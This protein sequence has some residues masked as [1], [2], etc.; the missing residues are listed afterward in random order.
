MCYYEIYNIIY[1]IGIKLINN[2]F[3]YITFTKY[4]FL[5]NIEF[6]SEIV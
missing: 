1:I 2:I 5:I 3:K 6:S 4:I